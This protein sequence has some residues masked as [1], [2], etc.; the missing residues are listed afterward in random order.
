MRLLRASFANGRTP[1]QAR[2]AGRAGR[3]GPLHC[4]RARAGR[5]QRSGGARQAGCANRLERAHRPRPPSERD[6]RR[7]RRRCLRPMA[8]ALLGRA[9]GRRE[10]YRLAESRR[11]VFDP[12]RLAHRLTST[13]GARARLAPLEQLAASRIDPRRIPGSAAVAI[14]RDAEDVRCAYA[15]KV[16]AR[17]QRSWP[18]SRAERCTPASNGGGP[19]TREHRRN[20][21][22]EGTA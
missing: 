16:R 5:A 3:S 21:G 19:R 9:Q 7:A 17:G 15:T 10:A 4:A 6:S 11:P 8:H 13:S 12:K 14:R 1:Y 22:N 20:R 2:V 18:R